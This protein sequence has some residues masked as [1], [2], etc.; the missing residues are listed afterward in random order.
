MRLLDASD[1]PSGRELVTQRP[2]WRV[3]FTDDR[4]LWAFVEVRAGRIWITGY[5]LHQVERIR[6]AKQPAAG[7]VVGLGAGALV[8]A[9]LGGAPG[10][11]VGGII[12]AVLAASGSDPGTR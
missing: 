5:P 2:A 6:S 8:G 7:A 3:Q 4:V 12:G 1:D 9:A 10:A 11:I